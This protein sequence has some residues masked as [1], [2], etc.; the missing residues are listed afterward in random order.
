[1]GIRFC[2]SKKEW[3]YP[4]A[5]LILGFFY[6]ISYFNYGI[7]FNDEGFFVYG[8]ERVLQG[9]LPMSDFISYPPGSYFL[10]ALLFKVF[11]INLLVSRYMEVAFLLMNGVM[12]FYI[13]K[14]LMTK[15]IALIPSFVLV[16]FPGPWHKVFFTF[17]LL[18]PMVTL[19]WFL[20]KRSIPKALTMGWAVGISTIF[21]LESGLYALLTLGI[22]ILLNDFWQ[23]G[24]FVFHKKAFLSL[25]KDLSVF[26]L[27][28]L[29]ILL[30]LS[31]YYFSRSSLTGLFYSLREIA[32]AQASISE[33][34]GQ[35]SLLSAVT[36][37]HI[38]TL[39]HLFFYLIVLLYLC[40]FVKV[41]F[42]FFV[43]KRRDFPPTLPVLIMG[44]FSLTYA[45]AMFEKAHLLQSVAMAYLLFGYVI[46]RLVREKP[47]RSK[48]M[49]IFLIF[50][51]GLYLLDNFKWSAHFYT[52]S[53]SRLY[54]IKRE[55]AKVISLQKAKIRVA[56][57]EADHIYGFVS[58]FEGKNGYLMPLRFE[59]MVNF[60]TGLENPTRFSILVPT[61]ISE[62]SRQRQV[63]E[64]VEKHEIKYLLINRLL[65]TSQESS[66]FKN[67]A[68]IIYEFVRKRYHL[69]KEIG[70][71][72]IFSRG[73]L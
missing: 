13:G 69:E 14:R 49:L 3:I 71:Y 36:K 55:G 52:G 65:W 57:R 10:L 48:A 34:Y 8:A 24:N 39:S 18:F 72:L 50:L 2:F 25:F 45:Y 61:Y 21:K 35:P 9:Q 30:A 17:G 47:I 62:P 67:C 26:L 70:N 43:R 51:L 73:S 6:Y 60:L 4:L 1:M 11:G 7:S 16:A 41:I 46:Y 68:P 22:I 19:Y 63:I 29:S 31:L 27:G 20:E 38:G 33:D 44:C 5:I 58:F 37:F 54:A 66:G 40:L 15:T 23:D 59:P 64:E 42:D 28:F 32:L 56:K 53:I 12:M